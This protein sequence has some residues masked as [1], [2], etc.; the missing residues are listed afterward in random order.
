MN[1]IIAWAIEWQRRE[2][3][4]GRFP[5]TIRLTKEQVEYVM[6]EIRPY[7]TVDSKLEGSKKK[8]ILGMTIIEV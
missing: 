5:S 8:E 2:I 4:N 6:D 3:E 1:A 7:M